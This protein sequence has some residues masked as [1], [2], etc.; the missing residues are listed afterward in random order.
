MINVEG[1]GPVNRTFFS[2]LTTCLYA[3]EMLMTEKKLFT[4]IVSK[5]TKSRIHM[6]VQTTCT[7]RSSKFR[8]SHFWPYA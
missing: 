8:S 6:N 1:L 4:C 3:T 7:G 2:V 5:T